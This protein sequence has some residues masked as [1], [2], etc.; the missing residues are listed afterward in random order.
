MFAGKPGIHADNQ[1]RLYW[2]KFCRKRHAAAFSGS[3]AVGI[4]IANPNGRRAADEHDFA[5]DAHTK[6]WRPSKRRSASA[7]AAVGRDLGCRLGGTQNDVGQ[8]DKAASIASASP[9]GLV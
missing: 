1:N 6:A 8:R 3:D 2:S 9:V 4:N 5:G 7:P